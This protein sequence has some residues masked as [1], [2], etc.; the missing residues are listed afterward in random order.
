MHDMY[1]E[2]SSLATN[3]HD[4]LERVSALA[5]DADPK[6]TLGVELFEVERALNNA[7][8]RLQKLVQSSI[9]T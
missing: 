3:L 4:I 5:H 7:D 2:L 6:N 8:R 1:P 9:T